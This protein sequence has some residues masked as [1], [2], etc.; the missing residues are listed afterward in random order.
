[1][2]QSSEFRR[3]GEH[4]FPSL[5]ADAMDMNQ[6]VSKYGLEAAFRNITRIADT[7]QCPYR[8]PATG[9]TNGNAVHN[10]SNGNAALEEAPQ[11]EPASSVN[12]VPRRRM[13]FFNRQG[14]PIT[15]ARHQGGLAAWETR[16]AVDAMMAANPRL[17]RITAL[18]LYRDEH[19]RT[20]AT[21]TGP[22]NAGSKGQR[23][24]DSRIINQIK[25]AA[26]NGETIDWEEGHQRALDS[27]QGR[28]RVA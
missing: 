9:Q 25:K 4:V 17:S 20:R 15:E 6:Y 16:R 26:T 23:S 5:S 24:W 14:K 28:R 12:G 19:P 13:H 1:M 18:A 10:A 21:V 3:T 11:E 8:L 22:R 7:L 27:L 2:A